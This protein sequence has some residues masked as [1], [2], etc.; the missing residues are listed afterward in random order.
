MCSLVSPSYQPFLFHVF[1]SFFLLCFSWQPSFRNVGVSFD[2]LLLPSFSHF[3]IVHFKHCWVIFPISPAFHPFRTRITR[4]FLSHLPNPSQW[5][6][7]LLERLRFTFTPNGRREFLPRDQVF[8]LFSVY[9][10]LFLDKN[11]L[12][13]VSFNNRNLFGLFLSAYLLF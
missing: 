10:L 3:S 13:Y 5:S 1:I 8:P 9:S 11:K 4:P 7:P 12:F 6:H 2:R